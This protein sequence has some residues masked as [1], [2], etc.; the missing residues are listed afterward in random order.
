MLAGLWLLYRCFG[1]TVAAM[2][3][4]VNTITGELGISLAVMGSILGAWPLV[5]L[6]AAIPSGAL[7]DRFG[8]RRS[9]AAAALLIALSGLLRAT[10]FDALS[11]FVAV[12]VFGLGGPLISI[13]APKLISLWFNEK[14]R[15]TAMGIYLTGPSLGGIAALALT[16]SVLM[17][18]TGNSWRY[19]LLIYAAVTLL[20]GVIWLVLSAHPASRSAEDEGAETGKKFN[21]QV[22][23]Q[24][25]QLNVVRIVLIMCVG[26]FMFNHGLNNWLPEILRRGGM[27]AVQA[28]YWAAIP[29][30][31]G[32]AGSLI[33]PRLAIPSRRL[34]M[35]TGLFICAALAA[36]LIATTGGTVLGFALFL[37]GVAR[38]SMM[39]LSMLI[40]MESKDIGHRNM[41]AA[42]GLFFTAGE[43]GGVLGP[44]TLGVLADSTGS[45]SASLL[46]LCVLCLLLAL[47]S[48]LLRN[49][50][51]A[52]R[53]F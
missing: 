31:V 30:A 15:G 6:A 25:L 46:M 1:L 16:N 34:A 36:L 26:I 51:F 3:P 18:L 17:P 32:I 35:L 49:G 23:P 40:L 37:Q 41:G 2:A 27:S 29:T 11:L 5:Y 48:L 44:L 7:L 50:G 4:L 8:L 19:T 53:G 13:G 12:A 21:W 47:L 10:A 20:A 24:L 28:G 43:V 42:G 45:F 22:Y 52:R 39:S 38:S 33:I 9:L 14:D